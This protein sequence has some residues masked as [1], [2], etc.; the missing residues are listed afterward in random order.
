MVR[1]PDY[2]REVGRYKTWLN[3]LQGY[4]GPLNF[5]MVLYLYI[6][7]EPLGVKWYIWFIILSVLLVVVLLVDVVI[8]YP[9]E[10]TYN[11][12]KN[13]EWLELRDDVNE[14]KEML[15]GDYRP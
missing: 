8:I 11:T 14:I 15:K 3:R 7:Q 9:S 1:R 2:V 4:L 10:Q 12:R 6:V 5:M 13:P